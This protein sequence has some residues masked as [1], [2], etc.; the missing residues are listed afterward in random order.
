MKI[1]EFMLHIVAALLL[2]FISLGLLAISPPK[3]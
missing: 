1:L 2:A 3:R